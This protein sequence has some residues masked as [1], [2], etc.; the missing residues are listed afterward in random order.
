[1]TR[2]AILNFHMAA[3]KRAKIA[4]DRGIHALIVQAARDAGWQVNL[5]DKDDPVGGDG[6]HLV[7]NRA[8]L[9]PHCLCVRRCYMNPFWRIETSNYR[10]DWEVAAKSFQKGAASEWFLNHWRSRIFG[11]TLINS[12]GHIFMPLQ[13]KLTEQRHFQSQ[14][15]LQMIATTL[16]ADPTR[17]VIATLHPRETYSAKEL[18]RL[19]DMGSRFKVTNRPSM[20][21]LASCDYVVTENSAMALTGLFAKKPAVLFAEIDFHHIAGSVPHMGVEAAFE[22]AQKV[23]P[24]ASYLH[25]FFKENAISVMA[26]DAIARIQTRF[27]DHG[28]PM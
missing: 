11:D 25:W 13:G 7:Y 12:G 2:D 6:Y 26:K 17:N 16:A 14:S 5:R 8:V 24:F 28:W 19:S 10:W 27:R 1:M 20:E 21:V 22:T 23:Q 15:P 9:E 18:Q 3:S 4:E